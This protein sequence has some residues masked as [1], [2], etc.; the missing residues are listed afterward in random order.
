LIQDHKWYKLEGEGR[1][2]TNPLKNFE[3]RVV[4]WDAYDVPSSDAEDTSDMYIT[5][6]ITESDKQKTDTHYRS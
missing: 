2:I 1:K 4:I 3:L 6:Y 5:A